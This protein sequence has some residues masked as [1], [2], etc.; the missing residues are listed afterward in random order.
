MICFKCK[1]QI[2]DGSLHCSECGCKLSDYESKQQTLLGETQAENFAAE[3]NGKKAAAS[4]L[5]A[6]LPKFQKVIALAS[7]AFFAIFSIILVIY[8][9]IGPSAAFFHSDCGDTLLWAQASHDGKTLYNPDFGYAAFLP[10]GGTMIMLPFIGLTGVSLTTHHIGMVIF[11][12]LFFAALFYLCRSLEFSYPCS[13]TATGL[14]ALILCSSPKL[15]EIFYEHVLYYSIS[16]AVICV[17]LSLYIRLTENADDKLIAKKFALLIPVFV[18]AFLTALDGMQVVACAVMP[19]IFAAA[20]EV[21]FSKEK[22]INKK[23]IPLAVYVAVIAVAT[24][25]G[26]KI[27]ESGTKDIGVGYANA[28]SKYT[29]PNEW[30]NNLLKL[31][32][33]WFSLFGIEINPDTLLFSPESIPNILRIGVALVLALAPIAALIFI[34]RFDRRSKL[35]IY[36]HLGVTG[37]IMFGYI[38]G[39]LSGA[40]WRLSPMICTSILICVAG[41]KV[42]KPHVAL[43]RV[44]SLIMCLLIVLCCVNVKTITEMPT[45]GVD[46]NKYYPIA[47]YLKSQGLEYGFSTFWHAVTI[48]CITDSEVIVNN[49]DINEAGIAPC[50]YQTNKNW[51]TEQEGIDRYFFL[52]TD[53]ELMVLRNTA[54]WKYFESGPIEQLE[55]DGYT[56]FVFDNI[57]FLF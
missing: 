32:L 40:E 31:P 39:M 35:L 9:I 52:C 41:L 14:M 53:Y 48:T 50:P 21:V 10:F 27:F 12:V 34:N 18:L 16:I 54:D 5:A 13:F 29:M 36:A 4:A 57:N 11:T 26:L 19:V 56:I 17:M 1:A 23:H 43:R 45:N 37:V 33:H 28:Y 7:A 15:R 24:L 44:G 3:Q 51:F 2:A 46:H 42:F 30:I 22:L 6:K 8:Y 25:I 47:E 38:F 49:T 55:Y 20:C